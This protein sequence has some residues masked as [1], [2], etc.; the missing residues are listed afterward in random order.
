MPECPDT[1]SWTET[2]AFVTMR[3]GSS[4]TVA[5]LGERLMKHYVEW[6]D[7]EKPTRSA[8]CF[9]DT[10]LVFDEDGVA[11][12]HVPKGPVQNVYIFIRQKMLHKVGKREEDGEG[13]GGTA[14]TAHV[15]R[16]RM[17]D[18]GLDAAMQHVRR[19]LQETFWKNGKALQCN[20]AALSLAIRGHNLDRCFWGI[21]P[22]GVGQSLFSSHVATIIGRLH[23]YLDTNVYYSDDELRKQA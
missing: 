13:A 3:A 18:N 11:S 2:I 14:P 22:G 23:A 9:M 17:V 21:G 19:F 20:L 15:P 4:M 7:S 8:A 5:M 12:R 16:F 10:C 1:A 6:C